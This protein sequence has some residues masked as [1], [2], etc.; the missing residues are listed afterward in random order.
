[1]KKI[2][3]GF[4][5]ATALT[6]AS[7]GNTAQKSSDSDS[8]TTVQAEESKPTNEDV[9]AAQVAKIYDRINEMNASGVVDLGQ[10][11]QEFCTNYFLALKDRI[12]QYDENAQGDMRFMGDEGYHW[13]VDQSL[14]LVVEQITPQ[15][16][17][18]TE[19]LAQIRFVS[20]DEDDVKGMTLK[21]QL[22][23]GTWKVSNWLDPEVYEEGGYVS[24]LEYYVSENGI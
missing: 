10:L 18:E 24:M 20:D 6:A 1:M 19:A 17:S 21:L 2:L 11:E 23:D 4:A 14:P 9:I 12:E 15:L 5:I 16:L 8:T 7:C 22:E 13:L 3:Y